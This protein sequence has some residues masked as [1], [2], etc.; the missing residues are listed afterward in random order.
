MSSNT[1]HAALFDLDGVLVDTEPEYTRIWRDI[2]ARFPTGVDN[3]PIKIKGTTLKD[4]LSTYY[5]DKT[6]HPLIHEMLVEREASMRYTLFDGVMSFLLQLKE[7]GIP[8]AIV[9]SSG[10][11]KMKR[12]FADKPNFAVCFADVITDAR[13]KHSKPDPEGYIT[14]ARSLGVNAEDCFVFEDSINGLLA[15]RRAWATV[16]AL[17]TSN[18]AERLLPLA[19][20][21]LPS[22]AGF[23]V[24][25]MLATRACRRKG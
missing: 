24:E 6:L 15:G 9:T 17:S 5:P 25:R 11:A 14:A 2:D 8:A 13:V 20:A 12:L 1:L 18:P 21:V 7:A 16:I 4:I 22:F 10:E 19:D 3:F 23:T